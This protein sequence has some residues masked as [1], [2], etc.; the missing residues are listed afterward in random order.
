MAWLEQARARTVAGRARAR[1]RAETGVPGRAAAARP[2]ASRRTTARRV[3]QGG[4]RLL[5]RHLVVVGDKAKAAA[6]AVGLAQHHAVLRSEHGARWWGQA[7]GDEQAA[8]SWE[9]TGHAGPAGLG[10]H[11]SQLAWGGHP[12]RLQDPRPCTP[13]RAPR[14]TVML[15]KAAKWLRNSA[16]D[17]SPMPPTNILR[18]SLPPPW[19]RGTAAL[20]STRRPSM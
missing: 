17:T 19:S 6:G 10:P 15:P 1:T 8:G 3:L 16:S 5:H 14:P 20:A 4:A 12:E 7:V 18:V 11:A 9:G 13:G 2:L